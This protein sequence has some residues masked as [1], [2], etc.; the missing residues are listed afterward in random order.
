MHLELFELLLILSYI[1]FV[2]FDSFAV[3]ARYSA[4]IESNIPIGITMQSSIGNLNR[5]FGV[6]IAPQV[7]F[8]VESKNLKAF[9]IYPLA[10]LCFLFGGVATYLSFKNH[11]Y[12][13]SKFRGLVREFTDNGYKLSSYFFSKTVEE[14]GSRYSMSKVD[15]KIILITSFISAGYYGS[16]FYVALFSTEFLQYR[17][18]IFQLTGIATGFGTLL[19]SLYLNPKL[20]EFELA[21]EHQRAYNSIMA[22]RIL[23]TSLVPIILLTILYELIN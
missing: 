12:V 19:L 3:H 14:Q 11:R 22:G 9:D 2:Y 6:L 1:L 7:A 17:A 16:C 21:N 13:F 10:L 4:V 15:I 20:T 18:T 8:L 5:F 23:G